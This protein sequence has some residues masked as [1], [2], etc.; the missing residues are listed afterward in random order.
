MKITMQTL[1]VKK[2][3]EKR[4]KESEIK[5][6]GCISFENTLKKLKFNLIL[7]VEFDWSHETFY[8]EDS[9]VVRKFKI[10]DGKF[11]LV[12]HSLINT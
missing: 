4:S 10:T 2:K 1:L 12:P 3:E 8:T 6:S 7:E 9:V 11:Y 5:L